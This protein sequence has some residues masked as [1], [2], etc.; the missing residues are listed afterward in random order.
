MTAGAVPSFVKQYAQLG[1]L[2]AEGVKAYIREVREGRFPAPAEAAP[3]P[4]S[5]KERA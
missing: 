3:R 4:R 2:M 1:A 5:P